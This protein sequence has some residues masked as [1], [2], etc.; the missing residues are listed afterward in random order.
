M[1][2]PE[3]KTGEPQLPILKGVPS[4][5]SKPVS[6]LSIQQ[7]QELELLYGQCP[8]PTSALLQQLINDRPALA[9][10]DIHLLRT[11]FQSRRFKKKRD[12]KLSPLISKNVELMAAHESLLLLNSQLK[13]QAL[14]LKLENHRLKEQL[15][16]QFQSKRAASP[17]KIPPRVVSE[18]GHFSEVD[19][20]DIGPSCESGTCGLE[21]NLHE[22]RLHE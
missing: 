7:R 9:N 4:T 11:W 18:D 13:S 3:S 19:D 17:L 5:A 16:I 15:E 22:V 21:S 8:R 6:R 20:G 2:P 10:L 14:L 1:E 12:E